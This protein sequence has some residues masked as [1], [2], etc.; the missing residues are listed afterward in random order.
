MISCFAFVH[1]EFKFWAYMS[2]HVASA[3]GTAAGMVKSGQATAHFQVHARTEAPRWT[4][5]LRGREICSRLV[6]VN[7]HE[8]QLVFLAIFFFNFVL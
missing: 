3:L 6:R 1:R 7:I 5:E 8:N 2:T 4:F